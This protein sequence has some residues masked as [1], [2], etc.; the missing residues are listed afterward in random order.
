MVT[1]PP[2]MSENILNKPHFSLD[3][4]SSVNLYTVVNMTATVLW[5]IPSMEMMTQAQRANSSIIS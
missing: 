2:V 1:F 4:L 5:N 3:K